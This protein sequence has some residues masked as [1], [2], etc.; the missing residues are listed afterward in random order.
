[1]SPA[2]TETTSAPE[3]PAEKPRHSVVGLLAARADDDHEAL[4][5]EG[6]TWTWREVV[7]ESS[8]RARALAEL[9]T[10]GPFHV[11]VMLENVPEFLFLLGGAALAG[12]VV[13]GINPTR[14]GAERATD[15]RHTD[16]QLILT[17][18]RRPEL[19][20][21]DLCLADD[22]ILDVDGERWRSLVADQPATWPDG[23]LSG[24]DALMLLIFTSGSTGAPKAVRCTQG[25]LAAGMPGFTSDDVLYCSMP[26]FH[27]NA[28]FSNVVP[29]MHVGATI[30]L[31][32]RFSASSLMD[33]IR[34]EGVTFFNT[35]GRALAYVLATPPR[36]DDREHRL[37]FVLAPEASSHDVAAFRDRFGCYVVEGY[38]SSEGGLRMAPR[39]D[40]PPGALGRPLGG[41]DVVVV[42]PET[43]QECPVA[44]FGPDGE[45]LNAEE[46]IGEIVRRDAGSTFEGYYRNDEAES[47]RTRGGWFWS[48][49]L[50]YRTESGDFFFAGRAGEWIRVDGENF[51]SAPVERIVSGYPGSSGAAVFGVPDPVTGDRVM[52]VLEVRPPAVFDPNDFQAFLDGQP[53]L[54]TK[55]A[56]RIVRV[57]DELP[58]TAT[59]K[60]DKAAMKR[61][62]WDGGA[63]AVGAGGGEVWWR[64]AR[65]AVWSRM[66][67]HDRDSLVDEFRRHGRETFLT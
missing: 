42:D 3:K 14:R 2:E 23:E 25:R 35:V 21:E 27:G 56:P 26:L 66:T 57:V 12:A 17:D 53:D 18:D 9:R 22:R 51:A 34:A 30:V 4:R 58:I 54:G 52:A 46:A 6:R 39:P 50:A 8:R 44:R 65:D 20:G 61:A 36:E 33:E 63:A 13:V 11:G 45:L 31:K 5:F 60:V 67:D 59:N 32:R 19:V 38:G 41:A 62:R 40:S 24:P 55:W 29:A 10:D 7:A 64:P 43:R 28:L 37:K 15:I 1:M 47:E 49:D 48:G 16:C